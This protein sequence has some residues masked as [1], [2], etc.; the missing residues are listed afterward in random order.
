[1]PLRAL[2]DGEPVIAPFLNDDEWRE[3]K[4]RAKSRQRQILMPCCSNPGHPAT[5]KL[6]TKFFA[7]NPGVSRGDKCEWKESIEHLAAKA[8]IA[9]ACKDAGYDP[10]TEAVG[11]NWRADVLAVKDTVR[12][13]FEVQW[14]RQTLE[15]TVSRQE[16]YQAEEIRGC[17]FFRKPP[18]QFR[19]ASR[20]LPLFPLSF[21]DKQFFIDLNPP[22]YWGHKD[23]SGGNQTTLK[24]FVEALL[25][26]RVKFCNNMKANRIQNLRV[27]F[28]EINCW[29]CK[30]PFHQYYVATESLKTLCGNEIPTWGFPIWDK[31]FELQPDVLRVVT[32]YQKSDQGRHLI[33]AVAKKRFSKTIQHTYMSFGCPHCD[34]ISGDWFVDE[35]IMEAKNHE[36]EAPAILETEI[37]FT[38]PIT[39][40]FPHWCVAEQHDFCE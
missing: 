25:T 38:Q 40:E 24:L 32:E 29:N 23:S 36:A 31:R 7:H 16:R 12:V 39:M 33:Q 34:A 17:W 6:G 26:K 18:T 1:M 9:L 13:A 27:V 2:I 5:S 4:V 35:E 14:S 37:E 8:E 20:D 28:F 3:L 22:V 19:Q 21:V 10:T 11:D 30:K 15:E